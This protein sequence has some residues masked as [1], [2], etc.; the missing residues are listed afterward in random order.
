MITLRDIRFSEEGRRIDYN[1]IP[2][3]PAAK[4]F[5]RCPSFFV[6]YEQDVSACP[7]AIAVIPFVA[8]MLPIAWFA[9][10]NL[11]VPEI[12]QAFA[13][14]MGRLRG[15]FRKMYP[16]HALSGGLEAKR[17][18]KVSWPGERRLA[19]FSGGLDAFATLLRHR[20]EQLELVTLFGADIDLFDQKQWNE[21][22]RHIGGE[23]FLQKFARHVIA[24]NLRTFY[25]PEVERTLIFGWWGRVQ[26]G[27]GMLGLLAPLSQLRGCSRAYIASSV[28]GDA[29]GSS[30]ETDDCIRWGSMAVSND[31]VEL[32]RQGK[33][34]L[35]VRYA[36]DSGQ[37]FSL[38]V[39]YSELSKNLNCGRCEKCYRTIMNLVLANQ[40][41][42]CFSLPFSS[43]TYP[44]MFK[45]LSRTHSSNALRLIWR[46][47]SD[48]ARQAVD[49]SQFF[50]LADREAETAAIRR[51]A[52]GEIDRALEWN[53]GAFGDRV[54]RWRFILRHQYPS[55]NS[56]LGHIRNLFFGK[57]LPTS[58]DK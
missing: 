11:C 4:F 1:Y 46:E 27:L 55:V 19:L 30:P 40:D 43:G 15:E 28:P 22:Q 56:M 48:R 18:I 21:C 41:P 57:P 24:A 10:F 32:G 2:Q 6:R 13:D 16:D 26:H 49:K 50:V 39:C 44:A 8:N 29:W 5:R 51:I 38:R 58:P 7:Q 45:L 3:G 23:P 17:L 42:R 35:I 37:Y 9:G 47:I 25:C 31:G 12:D 52:D 33:A 34:D 20:D 53:Q 54:A 36:R 14:S